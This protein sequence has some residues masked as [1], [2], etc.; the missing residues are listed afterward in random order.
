[1]S[2]EELL[3]ETLGERANGVT[4]DDDLAQKVIRRARGRRGR[5]VTLGLSVLVIVVIVVVLTLA[6]TVSRN[7]TVVPDPRATAVPTVYRVVDGP[8]PIMSG[9]GAPI[10][11]LPRVERRGSVTWFVTDGVSVALPASVAGSRGISA[12][13]SGWVIATISDGFTGGDTDSG[14]QILTVS[15]AGAVRSLATGAIRSVAVSP[16]GAQV[17]DIE[18]TERPLWAVQLVT[19][20]LSDGALIRAVGLSYGSP[21]SWPFPS[22]VWTPDGIVASNPS[23]AP[24]VPSAT[25]LVQGAKITDL[26]PITNAYGIPGSSDVMLVV[27]GKDGYCIHRVA[28]VSPT[29]TDPAVLCGPMR[30]VLA[31][32][33]DVA[34]VAADSPVGVAPDQAVIVSRTAGTLTRLPLA[35]ELQQTDLNL[36]V[37][38]SATTVLVFDS[39]RQRWLRWDVVRNTVETAPLPSGTNAAVSW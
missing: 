14:A 25:V 15:R 22:L 27:T 18:T 28:V 32:T 20:R 36:M 17:A 2:I 16:D 7:V 3:R 21:G 23:V 1:M 24:S 33:D 38:D 6:Q 11:L 19:R 35:A 13:A 9:T 8:Q 37:A 10:G 30:R 4:G 39:D 5:R 31:L 26:A 29:I 12:I 34:V